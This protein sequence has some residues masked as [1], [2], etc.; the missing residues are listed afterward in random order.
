LSKET[1]GHEIFPQEVQREHSQ[2]EPE[3]ASFAIQQ[4]YTINLC[5]QWNADDICN[6]WDKSSDYQSSGLPE[7]HI[8]VS[9]LQ[10]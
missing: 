4:V 5:Q 6:F 2:H 10:S 7:P 8:F 1:E 9:K 3:P